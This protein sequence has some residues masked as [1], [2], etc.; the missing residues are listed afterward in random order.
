MF[1]RVTI[2]SDSGTTGI[3]VLRATKV[4][5]V[6]IISILALLCEGANT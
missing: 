6:I 2:Y 3:S 5:G 4:T 1:L